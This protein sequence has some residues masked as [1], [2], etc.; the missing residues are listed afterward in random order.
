MIRVQTTTSSFCSDSITFLHEK[1]V[2]PSSRY[3]IH[4]VIENTG[5]V[6]L[7]FV[8]I[9]YNFYD[10]SDN[11]IATEYTYTARDIVAVGEKSTYQVLTDFTIQE[12]D[13]YE[14]KWEA[15]S[16]NKIPYRDLAVKSHKVDRSGFSPKI[17]GEIENVGQ[18]NTT[19]V[20]ILFVFF[21]SGT[22]L[23]VD[24]TYADPTD[25]QT[26]ETGIFQNYVD[27][28]CDSFTDYEM[29]LD[30]NQYYLLT[31]TTT[32]TTI[33]TTTTS[34]ETT[35]SKTGS[36]TSENTGISGIEDS[37]GFSVLTT[38]ISLT[39][40]IIIYTRRKSS[41]LTKK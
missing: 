40:S 29:Y 20:K 1:V 27:D 31:T 18:H 35:T 9:R 5:T 6:N 7:E 39:C 24:Y 11:L 3:Y 32:T 4:G 36:K 16:V 10:N 17:I 26:G 37:P 15:H 21:E 38:L 13:H 8:K 30:C 28:F 19:F 22:F 33:T 25:I 2:I 12:W 23:G 41:N 34:E 14:V